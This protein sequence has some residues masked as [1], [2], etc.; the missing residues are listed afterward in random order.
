MKFILYA[1]M[2]IS[3]SL[4]SQQYTYELSICGIFQDDAKYLP[5]WIEFHQEQGVEHFFLYYNRSSDDYKGYLAPYIKRGLVELKDWDESFRF[6]HN[7]TQEQ[8]GA[9]MD[10]I[11]N[12]RKDC[13]WIAFLDTDEFLFSP[14]G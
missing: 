9:Y 12:H 2:F 8:C 14:K 13:H 4:F 5:E 6:N 1:L 7:W 11:N 10:C 3:N